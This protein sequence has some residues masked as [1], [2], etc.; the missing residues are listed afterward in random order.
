MTKFPI[1]PPN[2]NINR[3]TVRPTTLYGEKSRIIGSINVY[4]VNTPEY[5]NTIIEITIRICGF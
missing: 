4:V 2:P 1:T 3:H 5:P